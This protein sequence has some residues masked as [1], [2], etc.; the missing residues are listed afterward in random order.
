[1][2]KAK[3]LGF[4]FVLLIPHS[5]ILE[6]KR[7]SKYGYEKEELPVKASKQV[8]LE[9]NAKKMRFVVRMQGTN[10]HM[11]YTLYQIIRNMTIYK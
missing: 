6:G 11:L 1:V 7:F 8:G 10:V 9:I 2:R 3:Y 5:A 4:Y